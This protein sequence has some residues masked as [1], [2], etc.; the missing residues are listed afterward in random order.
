MQFSLLRYAFVAEVDGCVAYIIS[1]SFY[2][3]RFRSEDDYY[4]KNSFDFGGK[5][6]ERLTPAVVDK[7]QYL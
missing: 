7:K 6:K 3:H 5:L 2:W 4:Y 1:I